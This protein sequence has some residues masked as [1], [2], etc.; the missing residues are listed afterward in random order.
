MFA[1]VF[2]IEC[3]LTVVKS[4]SLGII[5][6]PKSA[7]GF[8]FACEQIGTVFIS[9]KPPKVP[10]TVLCR[11]TNYHQLIRGTHGTQVPARFFEVKTVAGRVNLRKLQPQLVVVNASSSDVVALLRVYL[12][13]KSASEQNVLFRIPISSSQHFSDDRSKAEIVY[14]CTK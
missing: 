8:E 5:G 14:R 2:Q 10:I 12:C 3:F 6:I 1:N 13:A 11:K 9:Q 4:R 7:F